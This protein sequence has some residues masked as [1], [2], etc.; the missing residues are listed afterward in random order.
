MGKLG[1]NFCLLT[2]GFVLLTIPFCF[3]INNLLYLY[4][5]K[6]FDIFKH[7]ISHD[8]INIIFNILGHST[9]ECKSQFDV[10]LWFV[11]NI[12]QYSFCCWNSVNMYNG[13]SLL[14]LKIQ[15]SF[16]YLPLI[17]IWCC[18]IYIKKVYLYWNNSLLQ[19]NRWKR[20]EH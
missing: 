9:E 13:I 7:N 17:Q 10:T 2:P 18:R 12:L 3:L 5:K 4:L 6:N 16:L 11:L 15:N 19:I 14:F 8:I 20:S 1:L